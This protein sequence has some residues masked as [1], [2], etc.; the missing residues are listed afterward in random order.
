MS[1]GREGDGLVRGEEHLQGVSLVEVDQLMEG[2]R[3]CRVDCNRGHRWNPLDGS[4]RRVMR[5]LCVKKVNGGRKKKRKG[6]REKKRE[7]E[8]RERE[9]GATEKGGKREQKI[10]LVWH[11]RG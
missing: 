1:T 4:G 3:V 5:G 8:K 2:H 9:C 10:D 6:K 7:K 11:P